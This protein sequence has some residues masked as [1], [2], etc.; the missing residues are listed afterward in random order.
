MALWTFQADFCSKQGDRQRYGISTAPREV[1]WAG[2]LLRGLG[3]S[4]WFVRWGTRKRPARARSRAEVCQFCYACQD[5]R[6]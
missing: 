4:L 5:W 6:G 2:G 3:S 1:P